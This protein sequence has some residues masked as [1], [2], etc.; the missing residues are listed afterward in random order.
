MTMRGLRATRKAVFGRVPWL[1]CPFHVQQ[2]AFATV[3]RDSMKKEGTPDS[4][5]I[6]N[7]PAIHDALEALKQNGA[8]SSQVR[9]NLRRGWKPQYLN[10]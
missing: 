8:R 7:P 10:L 1:R 9:R 3:P 6:L 5:D 4:K 2:N